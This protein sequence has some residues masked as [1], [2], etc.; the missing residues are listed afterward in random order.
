MFMLRGIKS[1][2]KIPLTYNFCASQTI[3]VQLSFCIKKVVKAVTE[4]GF[5]IAASICDQGS[6]NMKALKILQ[7]ETNKLREEKG[8]E[9][10][11]LFF[12]AN[13]FFMNVIINFV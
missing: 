6:S 4:A 11:K 1:G 10:C 13:F 9:K 12:G 8:I 5:V 7:A 2:W 3:H